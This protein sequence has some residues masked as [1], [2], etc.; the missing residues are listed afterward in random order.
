MAEHPDP[1]GI[2]AVIEE[3][4]TAPIGPQPPAEIAITTA[5]PS[6]QIAILMVLVS[7]SVAPS[8]MGSENRKSYPF[9]TRR[10]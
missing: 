6:L 9:S 8:N 3:P 10:G 4:G 2:G 5:I 7:I 1:A